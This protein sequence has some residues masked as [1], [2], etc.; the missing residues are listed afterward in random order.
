MCEV[1][2]YLHPFFVNRRIC[3]LTDHVYDM[4]VFTFR[5]YS[6]IV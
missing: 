2:R 5:N 6:V 4:S 1:S 3:Q